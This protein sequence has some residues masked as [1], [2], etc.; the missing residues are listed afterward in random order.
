MGLFCCLKIDWL[1]DWLIDFLVDLLMS[2]AFS[3]FRCCGFVLSI[4]I[5]MDRLWTCCGFVVDLLQTQQFG[6]VDSGKFITP[7]CLQQMD[8]GVERCEA[9]LRYR[10]WRDCCP[11]RV[12]WRWPRQPNDHAG[13]PRLGLVAKPLWIVNVRQQS[14]I[15]AWRLI[16]NMHRSKLGNS[17]QTDQWSVVRTDGCHRIEWTNTDLVCSVPVLPQQTKKTQ[18]VIHVTVSEQA[19]HRQQRFFCFYF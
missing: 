4:R 10:P 16:A 12:T 9:R 18:L 7:L 5:V 6:S 8:G 19:L 3:T 15:G 2:F 11:P 13:N 17:G 1:I 14:R